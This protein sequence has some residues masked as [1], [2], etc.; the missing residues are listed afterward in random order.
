MSE[1]NIFERKLHILRTKEGEREPEIVKQIREFQ[2]KMEEVEGF[3]GIAL[4]G[5]VVKGYADESSDIDCTI[6]YDFQGNNS[7]RNQI[8]GKA[9]SIR[10]EMV[11]GKLR[12]INLFFED[13][14][15]GSFKGYSYYQD[16]TISIFAMKLV[17][18]CRVTIDFHFS[19]YYYICNTLKNVIL[20]DYDLPNDDHLKRTNHHSQAPARC[21]AL[22]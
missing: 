4:F 18:L 9:Q 17:N 16:S 6:L 3:V 20:Y 19:K 11:D 12:K 21:S 22:A 13:I 5:S 2:E 7:V 14:G 8:I 1:R 10:D 15:I